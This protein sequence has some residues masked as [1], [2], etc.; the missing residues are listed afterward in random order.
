MNQYL[1]QD[2]RRDMAQAKTFDNLLTVALRVLERMPHPLV[3]ISGPIT[4]G[5]K[6]SVEENNGVFAIATKY[7]QGKGLHVFD[8]IIFHEPLERI[9]VKTSIGDE[10]CIAIL[11]IFFRGIFESGHIS[12]VYFLPDW[13]SSR[14]SRWERECALRQG[15]E[16]VDMTYAEIT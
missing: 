14:G 12:T 9:K 1:T 3:Q 15:L 16:M 2:D 13:E 10:Y 4:T 5:G 7:L 6:G 11:E 8:F